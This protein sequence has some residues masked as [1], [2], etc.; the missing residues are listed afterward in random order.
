MYNKQESSSLLTTMSPKLTSRSTDKSGKKEHVCSDVEISTNLSEQTF[1]ERDADRLSRQLYYENKKK[2]RLSKDIPKTVRRLRGKTFSTPEQRDFMDKYDPHAGRVSELYRVLRNSDFSDIVDEKMRVFIEQTIILVSGL[3]GC[4]DTRTALHLIALYGSAVM[5]QSYWTRAEVTLSSLWEETLEEDLAPQSGIGEGLLGLLKRATDQWDLVKN[6]P[7]SDK[8][9][10]LCTGLVSAGLCSATRFEWNY[11]NVRLFS[12]GTKKKFLNASDLIDAL[13][14]TAKYLLETGMRCITERSFKPFFQVYD[15]QAAIEDQVRNVTIAVDNFKI[16]RMEDL[17]RLSVHEFRTLAKDTCE[18][19]QELKRTMTNAMLREVVDRKITVV[20]KALAEFEQLVRE[21]SFRY[22]PFGVLI[23]GDS[24]VGKSTLCHL[25]IHT[26]LEAQKRPHEQDNIAILDDADKFMST[27]T[28]STEGIIVD[29]LANTH[30]DYVTESPM[31]RIIK[32]QNNIATNAIKADVESKGKVAI[33]CGALVG[34]TNI[35]HINAAEYSNKPISILRRFDIHVEAKVKKEYRDHSSDGTELSRL[36][37]WKMMQ[38]SLKR[39]AMGQDDDFID[40]WDLDAYEWVELRQSNGAPKLCKKYFN[41]QG[42]ETKNIDVFTMIY[43]LQSMAKKHDHIQKVL[44]EKWKNRKMSFCPVCGSPRAICLKFEI[45]KAAGEKEGTSPDAPASSEPDFSHVE[46]SLFDSPSEEYLSTIEEVDEDD[47]VGKVVTVDEASELLDSECDE[48][49]DA[50]A[51]IFSH[52]K[53]YVSCAFETDEETYARQIEEMTRPFEARG[54]QLVPLLSRRLKT[55][56]LPRSVV[57][58]LDFAAI[59]Q[60]VALKLAT[61]VCIHGVLLAGACVLPVCLLLNIAVLYMQVGLYTLY[62]TRCLRE[63]ESQSRLTPTLVTIGKRLLVQTSPIIGLGLM[64]TGLRWAIRYNRLNPQGN[65]IPQRE[66]DMEQRDHEEN[67]W[68]TTVLSPL[69]GTQKQKA[70][71]HD[72]AVDRAGKRLVQILYAPVPDGQFGRTDLPKEYCVSGFITNSGE[73]LVPNHSWYPDSDHT[74]DPYVELDCIFTVGP[75]DVAGNVYPVRLNFARSVSESGTDFRLCYTPKIA[76]Q[77]PIAWMFPQEADVGVT[78]CTV[79]IRDMD[80]DVNTSNAHCRYGLVEH[81]KRGKM[82]GYWTTLSRDTFAGMCMS[83]YLAKSKHNQISGFHIAGKQGK[84]TGAA[85]VYTNEQYERDHSALQK[86][87]AHGLP[88]ED[89][90]IM[91][92]Q[93]GKTVVEHKEPHWKCP[94]RFMPVGSYFQVLGVNNSAISTFRSSVIRTPISPAVEQYCG[95]PC[96]HGPPENTQSWR[97]WQKFLA[98]ASSIGGG[99]SDTLLLWASSD[100]LQPLLH[101]MS[102]PF[103]R[104]RVRPLTMVETFSGV[105]GKRFMEAVKLQ[106]SCGHPIPGPKTDRVVFLDP[107]E[108]PN[109]ARPIIGDQETLDLIEAM[110]NRYRSGQR[111]CPMFLSHL[112]DEPVKLGSGKCRVFQIIPLAF[113]ALIRQY[114]LSLL[115]FLS[116]NPLISECMVGINAEGPEWDQF[117]RYFSAYGE[118]RTF[119]IDYMGYDT[120]Q[121]VEL[122][123]EGLRVFQSLAVASRNYS[124]DDL[125]IMRGIA[126]DLTYPLVFVNGTLVMLMSIGMSGSNLTTALNGIINSL[127]MRYSYAYGQDLR[128]LRPFRAVAR[129]GTYGDDVKG[130]VR[131]RSH[132]N[133]RVHAEV[134]AGFGMTVTMPDKSDGMVDYMHW[135]DCDFLKRHSRYC[136][137]RR[138]YVSMLDIKSIMRRLHVVTVSSVLTLEEQCVANLETSLHDLSFYPREVFEYYQ[139][140]FVLIAEDFGFV[141]P[142]LFKSYDQY[143]AEWLF[144]Y[145]PQEDQYVSSLSS[146]VTTISL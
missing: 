143:V 51:G 82:P 58:F 12:L 9:V 133:M 116:N 96:Q 72:Q 49:I 113:S 122:V 99:M 118:N 131:A 17:S 2:N 46:A 104:K 78:Q 123:A 126:T 50:Q 94:T 69:P 79:V 7:L 53:T 121:A 16:G 25:A 117:Y 98:R 8:L 13:L 144:K 41:F 84:P 22:C 80:G 110:K 127:S 45:C 68:A 89:G 100:Y 23:V 115:A 24:G 6:H 39:G 67:I 21:D 85:I 11:E 129:V 135:D 136:A 132:W 139:S 88:V 138:H 1:F 27:V 74:G 125:L 119:G 70:Q 102:K 77:K 103:Q 137:D 95:F 93:Y 44:L 66:S 109:H 111:C 90:E 141:I 140:K 19:L 55:V 75:K 97:P 34:T 146:E 60:N 4:N 62:Y 28:S 91:D 130:T 92:P 37:S 29:D 57:R 108:H 87:V 47:D 3:R 18:K 76:P 101:E 63:L 61:D 56:I 71:T 112:K 15:G 35:P 107:E 10:V 32:I 52:V 14:S 33:R 26:I 54:H 124:E 134:C 48:T 105:D 59:T 142:N 81:R 5:E 30:K 73:I 42:K 83:P 145:V 38:E 120:S 40:A 43:F 64:L 20:S 65:L 86:L 128:C 114:F 31:N 36:D 106:T